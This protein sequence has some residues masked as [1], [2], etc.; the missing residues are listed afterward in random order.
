MKKISHKKNQKK[1]KSRN[2]KN[3]VFDDIDFIQ[4]DN[5]LYYASSN[6]ISKLMISQ[7]MKKNIF[8]LIHD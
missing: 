8:N 5:L 6:I 2:D 1:I 4:F 3:D 7:T